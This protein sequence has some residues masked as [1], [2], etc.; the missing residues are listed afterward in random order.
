[1]FLAHACFWLMHVSGSTCMSQL[2]CRQALREF[3][4]E[5]RRGRGF[6]GEKEVHVH[7]RQVCFAE[8]IL[9]L[10]TILT[11][12]SWS[13]PGPDFKRWTTLSGGYM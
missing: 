11:L 9:G 4:G 10:I 8:K 7:R 5:G 6:G 2:M 1:M 13:L 12:G 3:E